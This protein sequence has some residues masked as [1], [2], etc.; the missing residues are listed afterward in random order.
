MGLGLMARALVLS[1]SANAKMTSW[2]WKYLPFS[3]RQLYH[4]LFDKGTNSLNAMMTLSVC[5]SKLLMRETSYFLVVVVAVAAAAAAV[6]IAALPCLTQ[7]HR[8]LRQWF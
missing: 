7:S 6:F 8:K 3:S 5:R 2:S 1:F 4:N